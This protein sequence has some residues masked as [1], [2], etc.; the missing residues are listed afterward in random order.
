MTR[1]RSYDYACGRRFLLEDDSFFVF[2]PGLVSRLFAKLVQ[3]VA[4]MEGDLYR[5]AVS[6]D[7]LL[8]LDTAVYLLYLE[9]VEV[10]GRIRYF[11]VF[12]AYGCSAPSPAPIAAE[13]SS[14]PS[15]HEACFNKLQSCC[16]VLRSH[17]GRL[18]SEIVE[19]CIE[20]D[21]LS[22]PD[23]TQRRVVPTSVVSIGLSHFI[24]SPTTL[25]ISLTQFRYAFIDGV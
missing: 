9:P 4:Q 20:S 5:D 10:M 17:L 13:I 24:K 25:S 14:S 16:D 18:G 8:L 6:Y 15:V 2:V 7:R 21:D 19:Y 11:D 3:H 1:G 23:C 12:V 22:L